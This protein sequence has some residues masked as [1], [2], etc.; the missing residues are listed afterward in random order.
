[1]MTY[2]DMKEVIHKAKIDVGNSCKEMRK[3]LGLT[4]EQVAVGADVSKTT[5]AN[6]EAGSSIS[7]KVFDYLDLLSRR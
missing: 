3:N 5:V 2:I 1:M 4:M 6:T 7:K